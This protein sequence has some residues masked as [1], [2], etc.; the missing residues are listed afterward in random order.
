MSGLSGRCPLSDLPECAGLARSSH[1]YALARPKAPAGPE[2][3][4]AAAEAFS[5][6]PN[7]CG[8]RQIAMRP[9]AERGVAIA[10]KT[11]LKTMHET[12]LR[13]GM[14]RET[15]RR[16]YSSYK[17]EVGKVLENV[18]GRGFDA[19][20]PW[21]K[22]GTD[23]AEL[24][25]KRGK[26]RFAPVY[27]FGS[28]EIVARSTSPG[29]NMAQQ[30]DILD[31]LVGKMPE[32]ATPVPHSDMGWQYQHPM[33]RARLRGAGIVQSM[34]RKGNRIDNGATGQVLGHIKDG[35]FRGREWGCFE[36]FKR[37]LDDCIVLWNTRRRQ[38]RLKGLTPEEFRNRSLAA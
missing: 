4:E 17:G 3:W 20:G 12:G 27:D 7:G 19:D 13:C 5:G 24:E 11:V 38:V 25:Q 26:A 30:P 16:R 29:P 2:P 33:W 15:D 37:D 22:T 34:P 36:D 9:R 1:Y 21:Q 31:Q 18:L 23:V 28:K 14:R 8:H 6:T 10:D 35:L 32:G